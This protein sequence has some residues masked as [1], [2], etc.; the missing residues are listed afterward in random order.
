MSIAHLSQVQSQQWRPF[1]GL[2]V[3]VGNDT[4]QRLRGETQ[5]AK[6]GALNSV[7]TMSV[8][9]VVETGAN[10]CRD[11]GII[12]LN[13]SCKI[14]HYVDMLAYVFEVVFH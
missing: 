6:P 4:G 9:D 10:G 7:K 11:R 12:V 2:G 8:N 1:G 5:Q 14:D 3:S 13:L